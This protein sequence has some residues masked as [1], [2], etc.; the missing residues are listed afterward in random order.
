[1][2]TCASRRRR[3][4]QNATPGTWPPTSPPAA[5]AQW[6]CPAAHDSSCRRALYCLLR[7]CY[8]PRLQ[9]VWACR[10]RAPQGARLGLL[11]RLHCTTKQE[12]TP[13][14]FRAPSQ[15]VRASFERAGLRMG[16]SW[17]RAAGRVNAGL[18][19]TPCCN[20]RWEISQTHH[21]IGRSTSV[22]AA[23]PREIQQRF[24]VH[25]LPSPSGQGLPAPTSGGVRGRSGCRKP[26]RHP[27][28]DALL[29]RHVRHT[30]LCGLR[31]IWGQQGRC[32]SEPAA[33]SPLCQ[34]VRV[35]C[36]Q[37]ADERQLS[38]TACPTACGS[39]PG[40]TTAAGIP[41]TAA[42]AGLKGVRH[43]EMHGSATWGVG[44]GVP[45]TVRVFDSR[46][47]GVCALAVI[48]RDSPITCT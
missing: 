20:R 24:A 42:A 6:A 48:R 27:A 31:P 25:V 14:V 1:L 43:A 12:M 11:F 21:R 33:T 34:L 39:R 30:Q 29:P 22:S 3:P 38:A 15:E 36:G 32:C 5:I 13:K 19:R 17:A 9:A 16:Q 4:R 41:A 8:Q 2:H 28:G 26:G 37:S 45:G 7:L 10:R 46:W 47:H 23:L 44:R 18:Q 40:R 35:W